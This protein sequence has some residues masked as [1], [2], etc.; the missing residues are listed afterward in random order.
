[1]LIGSLPPPYGGTSVSFQYLIDEINNNAQIEPIVVNLSFGVQNDLFK[2]MLGRFVKEFIRGIIAIVRIAMIAPKVHI[3]SFHGVGSKMH[4]IGG[5]IYVISKIFRKPLIIRKF[6]G[7]NYLDYEQPRRTIVRF[8]AHHSN[9]Y[10]V[11]TK[12][13]YRSACEDGVP[14]AAWYPT[15]RPLPSN[16][17]DYHSLSSKCRKFIYIGHIR[18]GRGI[19]F[20]IDAAERFNKKIIVDLYGPLME[21]IKESDFH[22]LKNIRYLGS[23]LP[24]NVITTYENYDACLFPTCF[25]SEG[26]PGAIIEAMYAGLPVISSSIGAIPEIVDDSNGILIS[27]NDADSLY[28]AIRLIIEDDH[29]FDKLKRGVIDKR[30]LFSTEY[31]G[32]R[33]VDYCIAVKNGDKIDNGIIDSLSRKHN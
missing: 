17:R 27:P 29:L 10:L 6:G 18:P 30:E 7:T 23:L 16:L 8:L 22:G 4:Y 14:L 3:I 28:N 11:Q 9:L 13:L 15:N 26:Y 32:N 21:G 31:W 20:I 12:E 2:G 19:K 1:M 24:E 5:F 33:F 25:H